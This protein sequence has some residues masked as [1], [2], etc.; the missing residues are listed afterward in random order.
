MCKFQTPVVPEGATAEEKAAIYFDA[1]SALDLSDKVEKRENLTYLSWANAWAEFKSCYPSATYNI[2]KNPS[3]GL[4]YFA[5]PLTGIMV[6]TEVSVDGITHQMWLPVMD[7]KNKS[8]KL[9]PYSYQVWDTYKKQYVEKTVAAAD[10]FSIN[11]TIMRCLVKNLAMF[12]LGL[13]I[14]AGEDVPNVGNED[15]TANQQQ[16]QPYWQSAPQKPIDPLAGIKNAINAAT[17][18]ATLMSLYL[19]HQGEIEG[20]PIIKQLLTN[21]KHQL[22][23]T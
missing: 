14:Y 8:Q 15:A 20:N 7:N 1:L 9:T 18:V 23:T 10:M 16:K 21:R 4:P 22:Q 3:T 11:K 13:Y 19:D 17:D 2:V 6:F 5:D 12:G